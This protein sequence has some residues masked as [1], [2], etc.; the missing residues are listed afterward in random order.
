MIYNKIKRANEL[1]WESLDKLE[2]NRLA[3]RFKRE[4]EQK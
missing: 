2:K 1:W 4:R 3:L